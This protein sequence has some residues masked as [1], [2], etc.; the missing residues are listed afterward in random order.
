[1]LD[2]ANAYGAVLHLLILKALRFYNVPD[3]IIKIIVVYFAG[4]YGRFFS[5]LVTSNWQKFE[6]GIF[7]GCVI[8]VIIFVLCMNLSDEYL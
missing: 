7:M 4:V 5:R 6:I 2:L 8:S 1:M 3:K